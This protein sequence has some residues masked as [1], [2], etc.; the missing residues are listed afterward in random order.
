MIVILGGGI[1][2][3][4]A[5][6]ELKKAGKEFILLEATSE[7]GGKIKSISQDGFIIEAGPNTVL[8]NN[9]ETK[10]LLE[11]LNLWEELVFPE[12]EA[13]K[14]RFV[15]KNG[16]IEAIPTSLQEALKS[17]LF[18]TFTLLSILREPFIAAKKDEKDESLANFSRRRFGKQIF[19][20]FITP[21]VTGIYAGDPEKMSI[22][23]TLS[24]LKEAEE[25][26][27][28]VLK[29]IPKVMKARKAKNEAAGIPKQ[30]IF[31]F[32]KGLS[33]LI[34]AIDNKIKDSVQTNAIV[35]EISNKSDKY[36][37]KYEH[38]GNTK[39]IE[40]DTLI[41]CLPANVTAC[42]CKPLSQRFAKTLES[43]NYVPAISAS[44]SVDSK[45]IFFQKDAFGILSRKDEKVP[46]L[47]LL[48]SSRFFPHTAPEG[49]E[50]LTVIG[51][52]ARYPE[53]VTK[54]DEEILSE[55]KNSISKLLG[56]KGD[57]KTL[58]L[59]RWAEAIPQYEVGYDKIISEI[60]YF[61]S[62]H[63]NFY[64]AANYY[65]GVSV[66]DCIKNGTLIA[67]EIS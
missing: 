60:E 29:G 7:L 45:D 27:G 53:L 46:F 57:L 13:V 17:K 24:V 59:V 55:L 12:E 26:Y 56:T 62:K 37:I 52:G 38:R 28:S 58:K 35:S 23:H 65:K 44:F 66:S 15:L 5:A 67:H 3:L 48:F 41:C 6:L 32:Q 63:K 39:T 25:K 10:Q 43:I 42:L 33:R 50:L 47:G 22:K 30:K 18:S 21:F 64:I 49:K 16:S 36:F 11:S 20:D 8:I 1:S 14:K 40:A 34:E 9:P 31:T 54:N 19:E 2:G 51:G 61:L 4:S